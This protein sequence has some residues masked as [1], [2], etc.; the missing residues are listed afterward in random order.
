MLSSFSSNRVARF[1]SGAVI[2]RSQTPI[3]DNALRDAAPS[4][5]A[6]DKHGSRSARYTYIPTSDVLAGLRK[7]GF[8]PFEVRQGGSRDDE[9]RGF[10]KHMV[11]LRHAHDIERAAGEN[12]RELIL[13]N[14][15]DGTSSY[16]LMS[17]VFR[18]VCTNGLIA[19]DGCAQILRIAHKGDIVGN[20]IEGAYTIIEDSKRVDASIDAMKSVELQPDEQRVF[21][22]AAA[23][24]RYSTKEDDNG[25][26]INQ[27]PVTPEQVIQPRRHADIGS[28]L[29][30]TFNRAQENL[31]KG[32]LGYVHRAPDGRRS[33]R[34]TRPV[35]SIDGNIALNRALW[36]LSSEMAKLKGVAI[37]A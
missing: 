21:A 25:L 23:E 9:K 27:P 3:D 22:K 35:N 11:R 12:V 14:S 19:A 32:G 7:E 36:T 5:F 37:A 18:I 13:L 33:R 2:L 28:D 24:L 16:Q 10:T 6:A 26:I 15:H 20:V 29:W 31:T 34:D 4:V 17:G 1:G 30:K 8:F